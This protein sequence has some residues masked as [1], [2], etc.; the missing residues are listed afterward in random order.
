VTRFIVVV[1]PSYGGAEKRFFDVYTGLRRKHIDVH[2]IAPSLLVDL[3]KNDHPERAD[4]FDGLIEVPLDRWSVAK[5]VWRYA[6]VLRGLPRGSA[7]HYPMNCLWPLHFGRGDDLSMS[8]VDCKQI[9]RLFSTSRTTTMSFIAFG[10]VDKIDVLSPAIFEHVRA[11]RAGRKAT[12]TPGGTYLLPPL[13]LE[14][15]KD[16]VAVFLGRFIED[17]GILDLLEVA[18]AMW[19]ALRQCVPADFELLIAGYGPLE[20]QVRSSVEKSAAAGVPIRFVGYARAHDLM[21]RAAVVLSLQR[22]TNFPSRVVAEALV[23]GCGV[24]VRDS[25][26]SRRFGELP[27]L[28]YCQDSLDPSDLA[29]AVAKSIAQVRADPEFC[30][31]V[32]AAALARF[33]SPSYLRYFEAL[34]SR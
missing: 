20:S 23:S 9:P 24:V 7:F 26:D 34:L 27:G 25:G 21:R 4:V 29:G 33:N 6:R 10:F 2:Y 30:V 14:S 3:L 13:A 32:H 8:F 16:P 15:R 1:S 11:S 22:E 19:E 12:L 31:E 5:F 18:P 28:S 17:K